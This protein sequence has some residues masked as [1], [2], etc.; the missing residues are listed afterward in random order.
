M[1]RAALAHGS[2][3][4]RAIVVPTPSTM[5]DLGTRAPDFTLPDGYGNPVAL[6]EFAGAPA[7]VVIF[8]CNH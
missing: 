4:R 8:M 6:A 3:N 2:N 1:E 5:L 7:T